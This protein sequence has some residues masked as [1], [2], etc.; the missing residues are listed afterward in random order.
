[1]ALIDRHV[2]L[3][4]AE[5]KRNKEGFVRGHQH[6]TGVRLMNV[7]QVH[8]PYATADDPTDSMIIEVGA[9][10]AGAPAVYHMGGV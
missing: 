4:H 10:H 9:A 1:M 6:A 8:R 2:S 3:V 7:P 5:N